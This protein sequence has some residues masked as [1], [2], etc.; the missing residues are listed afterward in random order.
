MSEL[1]KKNKIFFFL[2][3]FFSLT[4]FGKY[5]FLQTNFYDFGLF[6]NDLY[7][8]YNGELEN[9]IFPY[10]SIF[11]FFFSKIFWIS[12][13]YTP[14]ILISIKS[15]ILASPIL[16]FKQ[17]EERIIYAIF[18]PLHYFSFFNYNLD[19]LFVPLSLIFFYKIK[20]IKYIYFFF[21]TSYLI[22]STI[23]FYLFFYLIYYYI[24]TKDLKNF[25]I[26]KIIL[27]IGFIYS[28]NVIYSYKIFSEHSDFYLYKNQITENFLLNIFFILKENFS[29]NLNIFLFS[30]IIIILILFGIN[31][32]KNLLYIFFIPHFFFIAF[33]SEQ[34]GKINNHYLIPIFAPIFISF[35]R[36]YKNY[37]ILNLSVIIFMLISFN[38]YPFSIVNLTWKNNLSLDNYL[39]EDHKIK[40]EILKITDIE[41]KIISVENSLN[42]YP[43]YL[44]NNLFSFPLAVNKVHTKKTNNIIKEFRADYVIIK[45]INSNIK[46]KFY[47]DLSLCNYSY[48]N[49]HNTEIKYKYINQIKLLNKFYDKINN[50]GYVI[51][52]KKIK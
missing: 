1:I 51:Y 48:N 47:N 29:S 42:Y 38:P 39:N 32:Q 34:F 24:K 9:L 31:T 25:L 36:N 27:I 33:G 6:L 43:L 11:K 41:N 40:S 35:I 13:E 28:L 22:K 8:I 26:I 14:Y 16:I 50:N 17:R 21:F 23:S 10:I 45:N 4:N 37:K 30:T 52:K 18:L 46:R 12:K 5:Y 19:Y 7:K 44:A 20:N 2:F 3:T 15:L 49:C